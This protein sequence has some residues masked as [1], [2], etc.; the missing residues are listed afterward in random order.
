MNRNTYCRKNNWLIVKQNFIDNPYLNHFMFI[1]IQIE[2][3]TAIMFENFILFEIVYIY[4]RKYFS[5]QK[6][7]AI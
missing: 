7:N 2:Q 4:T 3:I 1:K 5:Y 6:V